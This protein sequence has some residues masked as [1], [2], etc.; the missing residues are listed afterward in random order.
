MKLSLVR[1]DPWVARHYKGT[2]AVIPH[3]QCLEERFILLTNDEGVGHNIW[4]ENIFKHL[5]SFE[6]VVI[7]GG[8]DVENIGERALCIVVC[9]VI[10]FVDSARDLTLGDTATGRMWPRFAPCL[11]INDQEVLIVLDT[12]WR[13]NYNGLSNGLSNVERPWKTENM[14]MSSWCTHW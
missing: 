5:H 3:R 6:A 14:E 2:S 12:A 4:S 13:Y 8:G 10:V 11:V 1:T 9:I 7:E